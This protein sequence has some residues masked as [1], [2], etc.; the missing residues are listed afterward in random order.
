M[1][2][3]DVGSAVLFGVTV[4]AAIG[5]VVGLSLWSMARRR[6]WPTRRYVRLCQE[7]SPLA[8]R[9]LTGN[10]TRAER[11]RLDSLDEAIRRAELR[12][13]RGQR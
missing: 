3:F 13:L 7:R 2:G 6:R 11:R 1:S 12:R 10:M 8:M 9:A 5:I 4:G